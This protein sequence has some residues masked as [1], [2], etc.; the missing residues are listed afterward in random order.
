[1]QFGAHDVEQ[2]V[3]RGAFD[4]ADGR[5]GSELTS[6]SIPSSAI[7]LASFW[8]ANPALRVA[9]IAH[10]PMAGMSS[11]ASPRPMAA[12][13][14]EPIRATAMRPSRTKYT[15]MAAHRK[16]ISS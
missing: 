16:A 5:R 7:N 11:R 14:P 3:G 10:S 13:R 6:S 4:A 9:I 15:S 8:C 2:R 1:M 12:A